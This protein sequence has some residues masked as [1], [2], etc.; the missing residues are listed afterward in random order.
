MVRRTAAAAA[1]AA[2]LTA[3]AAVYASRHIGDPPQPAPYVA[4]ATTIAVS[5]STTPAPALVR[6]IAPAEDV[7]V[8]TTAPIEPARNVHS[9]TSAP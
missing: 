8:V 5:S 7:V 4:P 2:A 3:G 6:T 9:G 1:L